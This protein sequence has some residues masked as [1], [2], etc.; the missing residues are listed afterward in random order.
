MPGAANRFVGA[1]GSRLVTSMARAA[2]VLAAL[3]A[4]P[5]YW[6]VM[7]YEPIAKPAVVRLAWY[8]P[9]KALVPSSEVPA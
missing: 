4:L 6:A 7:L 1:G 8:E 5:T 3:V 2:E 9:F